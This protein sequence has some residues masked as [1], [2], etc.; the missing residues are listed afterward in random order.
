MQRYDSLNLVDN[1]D[2]NDAIHSTINNINNKCKKDIN[3]TVNGKNYNYKDQLLKIFSNKDN[4]LKTNNQYEQY[5]IQSN[6]YQKNKLGISFPMNYNGV[7]F[8]WWGFGDYFYWYMSSNTV[9]KI[10][11][12]LAYGQPAFVLAVNSILL[13]SGVGG[14]LIT[15]VDACLFTFTAT[16]YMDKV[17]SFDSGNGVYLGI[18]IL[19]APTIFEVGSQDKYISKVNF[20]EVDYRFLAADYI[21]TCLDEQGVNLLLNLYNQPYETKALYSDTINNYLKSLKS[22]DKT[23]AGGY[24]SKWDYQT[25]TY[26][27]IMKDNQGF[28]SGYGSYSKLQKLANDIKDFKSIDIRTT[29]TDPEG[30]YNNYYQIWKNS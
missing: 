9:K 5:L 22:I 12:Y 20:F 25:L 28:A 6:N 16:W 18:S 21:T 29:R 30:S 19:P 13:A 24:I 7:Y 8:P 3:Y 10:Q 23:G 4:L 2:L 27:F 1:Q 17:A 11:Q 15:L 14:L 26:T